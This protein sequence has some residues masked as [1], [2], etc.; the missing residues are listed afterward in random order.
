MTWLFGYVSHKG[1]WAHRAQKAGFM[2]VCDSLNKWCWKE[3]DGLDGICTVTL[4]NLFLSHS[5]KAPLKVLTT[6]G[7]QL[8]IMQVTFTPL[9]VHSTLRNCSV[10]TQ[11]TVLFLWLISVVP[12]HSHFTPF[13][14]HTQIH[15]GVHL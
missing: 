4:R 8:Y 5:T 2:H 11:L 7:K 10:V 6:P 1:L 15:L 9:C 14:S 13:V 3:K 12:R